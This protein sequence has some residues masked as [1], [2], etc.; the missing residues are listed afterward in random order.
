MPGNGHEAGTKGTQGPQQSTCAPK[1]LMAADQSI[2]KHL[3]PSPRHSKLLADPFVT[4][5]PLAAPSVSPEPPR[6][7]QKVKVP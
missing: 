1:H 5:N 3:E 2:V 4:L 6:S 7:R